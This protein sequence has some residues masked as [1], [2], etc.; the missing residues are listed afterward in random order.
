M[1]RPSLAY[2]VD[3]RFPGGTSAA[4]AREINVLRDLVR[5]EVNA[6]SARMFTDREVH[7]GLQRAMD[8]LRRPLVWDPRR[9]AADTVVL[10][11]PSFL[12]FD[13]E[14]APRILSRD[15]VVVTHENLL[16]PGGVESF[17]VGHCLGLIDRAAL[18][19]RKWIAPVSPWNRSTVTD[20]L[21]SHPAFAHWRVMGEDWHNICDFPLRD[22]TDAPADRRGRHSRPGFE[23]F[24]S[25]ADLDL[26]FPPHAQANVIL[27]ADTLIRDGKRRAHWQ[28]FPFQGIE[29]D[30]YF[31]MID[32]MVYFTA[33]TL[34]ES[35]G[36][37]LAEAIAAGKIVISDPDT[38]AV[39]DGAVIAARPAEVDGIVARFV[40]NP[41]LYAAHVRQAQGVLARFSAQAFRDSHARFLGAKAGAAA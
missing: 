39:F 1:I 2:V 4:V 19:V 38:A 11:N 36:R 15:L 16:R 10:H 28:L 40:A 34:K 17:D 37:V 23:K 20:W 6:I 18:S 3:P 8:E 24:P 31:N 21:A 27:G 12:K 26:C 41:A 9:I 5:I 30:S 13:R 29:I 7:A 14:F 22:P 25:L 35:F 32:F 33:P